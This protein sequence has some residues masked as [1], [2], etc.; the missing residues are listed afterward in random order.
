MKLK[1]EFFV[2]LV[3]LLILIT[4]LNAK[5]LLMPNSTNMMLI[6]GLVIGFLAFVG[7]VWREK[8]SDERDEAHIQKSGRLSFLAGATILVVGIAV[9]AV[10]HDIDPWL[11]YSLSGMVL[12]KLIARIFHYFR[13]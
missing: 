9:Q 13:N 11:I 7:L 1:L 3:I 4:F 12:T 10:M 6:V 2:S 8:A 5:S